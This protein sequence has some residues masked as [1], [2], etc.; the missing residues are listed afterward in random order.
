[1]YGLDGAGM[2][3]QEKLQGLGLKTLRL[4]VSEAYA[5]GRWDVCDGEGTS[6]GVAEAKGAAG[7]CSQR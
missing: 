6:A 2:S 7:V 3:T 1:M 5:S 4:S